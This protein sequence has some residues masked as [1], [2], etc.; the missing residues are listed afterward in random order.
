MTKTLEELQQEN[1]ELRLKVVE[2]ERVLKEG[3]SVNSLCLDRIAKLN[4]ENRDLKRDNETVVAQLYLLSGENETI[5]RIAARANPDLAKLP[6]SMVR[7]DRQP[8]ENSFIGSPTAKREAF[9]PPE[10]GVAPEEALS[11]RQD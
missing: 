5:R 1:D 8:I 10:R 4:S 2:Y 7:Y 3:A 9:M 11:R 6:N